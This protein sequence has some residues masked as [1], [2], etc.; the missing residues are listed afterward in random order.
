MIK[1]QAQMRKS[2]LH[3]VTIFQTKDYFASLPIKQQLAQAN[4]ER[5]EQI[6]SMKWGEKKNVGSDS[7][8]RSKIDQMETEISKH[9]TERNTHSEGIED[10]KKELTLIVKEVTVAQVMKLNKLLSNK[11]PTSLVD[12][13]ESFV[14]ILRNRRQANNVDV[15]M[16]F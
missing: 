2:N 1:H 8:L 6:A 13:L 14:A 10:L 16:Y 4:E 15:E 7:D 11:A 9:E 5:D 3:A 12:G